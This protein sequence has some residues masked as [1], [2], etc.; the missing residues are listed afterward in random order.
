MDLYLDA[1][2]AELVQRVL[3]HVLEDLHR[4]INHTDRRA[5]K[6]EL[7]AE[8]ALLQR[9]LDKVKQPAAIGI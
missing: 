6:A 4:E 8:E 1:K 7:K 9:I 5:F 2:E 3:A